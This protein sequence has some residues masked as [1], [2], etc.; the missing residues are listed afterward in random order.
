MIIENDNF[1]IDDQQTLK[2]EIVP[3]HQ[4]TT[5]AKFQSQHSSI[6]HHKSIAELSY[7]SL[8]YKVNPGDAEEMLFVKA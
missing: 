3:K 2:S 8:Q 1:D 4:D 7:D 5:Q 6:I